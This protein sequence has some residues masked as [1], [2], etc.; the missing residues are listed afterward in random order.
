MTVDDAHDRAQDVLAFW[1]GKDLETA[2]DL[3]VASA[4]WFA[5]DPQFDAALGERFGRD[6]ARAAKGELD[7]W[8][9]SPRR[10]LALL[11]LLDQFPRN[12][13]RGTPRAFQADSKA[14]SVALGGIQRGHDDRLSPVERVFAYLPLEHA[15]DPAMQE[16]SVALFTSLRDE[17]PEELIHMFDMFLDYAVQHRDV[18]ARFGRFPH[19]N[20]ILGRASTDEERAYLETPGS[21]F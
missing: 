2:D 17:A 4:R 5:N 1:F 15:E 21:G 19:R 16:Q 6:V 12:I 10:W 20:T 8:E 14:R 11:I 18:I 9:T 3:K 13:F 7:E